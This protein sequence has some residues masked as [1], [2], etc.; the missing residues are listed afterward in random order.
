LLLPVDLLNVSRRPSIFPDSPYEE[1]ARKLETAGKLLILEAQMT[2]VIGS[3]PGCKPTEIFAARLRT[4]VPVTGCQRPGPGR[5]GNAED[6]FERVEGA[7]PR[8][9]EAWIHA[10]NADDDF[11]ALLEMIDDKAQRNELWI[12]A[13][14]D[15]NPIIIVP[16]SCQE[17]LVRNAHHRMFH[18]AHAKVFAVIRRSY[19]WPTMKTDVR[20]ILQDCP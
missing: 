7:V 14:P 20:K 17:L 11:P 18:L 6:D 12:S 16:S 1:I 19:F 4:P 13:P 2:W 9:L 8:T 5:P 3:L 10:Q 15:S